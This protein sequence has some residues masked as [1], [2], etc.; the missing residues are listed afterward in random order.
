M[1]EGE[2]VEKIRALTSDLQQASH[3]LSDASYGD[4]QTS[5]QSEQEYGGYNYGKER[6]RDDDVI[7]ADYTADSSRG[8]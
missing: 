3:T 1:K 4:R 2:S 5:E 6:S 8:G 7:D